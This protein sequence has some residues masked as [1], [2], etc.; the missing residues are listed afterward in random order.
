MVHCKTLS[1]V[2][3]PLFLLILNLNE[4]NINKI[5]NMSFG[6]AACCKALGGGA[7]E[8]WQSCEVVRKHPIQ[9]LTAWKVLWLQAIVSWSCMKPSTATSYQTLPNTV[10]Q[11][12]LRFQDLFEHGIRHWCHN[13]LTITRLHLHLK[14]SYGDSKWKPSVGWLTISR[15]GQ[16]SCTGY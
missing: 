7:T 5:V 14:V 9:R 12:N 8:E 3:I 4:N 11:F 1:W 6:Q 16:R 10:S 15:D 2:I 13:I